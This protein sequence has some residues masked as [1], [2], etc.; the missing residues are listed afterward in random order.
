MTL[1]R[2][3]DDGCAAAHALD[4][5]GDR[6]ALLVLRELLLGP[7]RFTDLRA[8]L[9]AISANVLSQRLTDLEKAGVV[10][11]RKLAPPAASRVYELTDWGKEIEPIVLGLAHWGARSPLF[12]R[13]APIGADAFMLSLKAMFSPAYG[14]LFDKVVQLAFADETF[15]VRVVDGSLDINRGAAPDAHVFLHSDPQT[16]LGLAYGKHDLAGAASAGKF[17]YSGDEQIVIAFLSMFALPE[18]ADDTG[19]GT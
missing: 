2:N 18:R 9:P 6:W 16:M 5:V 7:K 8:G 11:R 19:Q 12:H 15:H 14:T 1:R 3:Y 17:S 10:R 4:L 13:G